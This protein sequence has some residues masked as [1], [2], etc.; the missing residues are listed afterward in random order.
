M[1]TVQLS[2]LA[3]SYSP[4]EYSSDEHV[5]M[6]QHHLLFKE[7][8]RRFPPPSYIIFKKGQSSLTEEQFA[9]LLQDKAVIVESFERELRELDLT[10]LGEL[11]YAG[12]TPVKLNERATGEVPTFWAGEFKHFHFRRAWRYWVVKGTVPLELAKVLYA[13]PIGHEDIRTNGFAGNTDPVN[14]KG[15]DTY[16]I[17]SSDGLLRFVEVINQWSKENL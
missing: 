1:K 15:V 12:V 14:M 4:L 7:F 6:G 3:R 9:S 13:D 2:N 10:V 11:A 8:N 17:D 5:F 16:H